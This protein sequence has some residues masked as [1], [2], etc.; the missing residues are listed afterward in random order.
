MQVIFLTTNLINKCQPEV[1]VAVRPG[2]E[3]REYGVGIR[4]ADHVAPSTRKRWY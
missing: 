2:L 1:F 3:S 4:H